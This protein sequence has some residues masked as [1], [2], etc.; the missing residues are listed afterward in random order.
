LPGYESYRQGARTLVVETVLF[1]K[2][3]CLFVSKGLFSL[4]NTKH[5]K[6]CGSPDTGKNVNDTIFGLILSYAILCFAADVYV[7]YEKCYCNN[8]QKYFF[9]LGITHVCSFSLIVKI[10]ILMRKQL[11][12]GELKFICVK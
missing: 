9:F 1:K 10:N 4:S 11:H 2:S 3:L 12:V 8:L 6:G 7:H 5:G